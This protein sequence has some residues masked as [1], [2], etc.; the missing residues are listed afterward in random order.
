[1]DSDAEEGEANPLERIP[2]NI[3][4]SYIAERGGD[5]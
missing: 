1:M 2:K 4:E 5:N 3:P